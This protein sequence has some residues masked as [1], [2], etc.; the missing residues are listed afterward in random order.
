VTY[1]NLTKV[2]AIKNKM[3]PPYRMS[4]FEIIYGQGIDKLGEL[5]ELINEH[6]IGRKYGKTMTIDSVK[7]DLDEFKVMLMDNEEFQASIK[8]QIINKINQTEIKI[9]Q[10]ASSE[11]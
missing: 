4:Q 9:E 6:E 11:L 3:S 8:E 5:M 10:D 7:Y 1:G 2:K